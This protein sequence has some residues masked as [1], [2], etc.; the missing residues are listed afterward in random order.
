MS[1]EDEQV[2]EEEVKEMLDKA[3]LERQGRRV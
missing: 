1:A 2:G 3:V